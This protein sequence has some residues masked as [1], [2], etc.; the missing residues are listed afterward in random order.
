MV[1]ENGKQ[2]DVAIQ[3]AGNDPSIMAEAAKIIAQYKDVEP[4]EITTR[5]FFIKSNVWFFTIGKA[6][7]KDLFS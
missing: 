6:Y 1:E 4:C 7:L 3:L 2:P 5:D